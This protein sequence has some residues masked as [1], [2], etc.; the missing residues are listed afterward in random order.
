MV[1]LIDDNYSFD[2]NRIKEIQENWQNTVRMGRDANLLLKRDG[3]TISVKDAA[4]EVFSKI[5]DYAYALPIEANDLKKKILRSLDIQK[6]K[7]RDSEL[8]PSGMILKEMA[9]KNITWDEFCNN[10]AEANKN[11]YEAFKKD[12]TNIKISSEASL[13]EFQDLES[14]K[15]VDFDTYLKD[16]LNAI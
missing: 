11:Y 14:S 9:E 2:V 5:Y 4:G 15:E 16:Y 8:T 1:S 10:K 13:K 7:I 6:S 12:T 3:K